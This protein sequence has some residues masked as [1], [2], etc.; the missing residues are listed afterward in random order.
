MGDL[1]A[2]RDW[3]EVRVKI[4]TDGRL[5]ARNVGRLLQSLNTAGRSV[6]ATASLAPRVEIVSIASG[7]IEIVIAV[8]ALGV[9]ATSLAFQIREFFKTNTGAVRVGRD[10]IVNDNATSISIS[11][12]TNIFLIGHQDVPE[13]E[14]MLTDM[15]VAARAP[16]RPSV[17]TVIRGPHFGRLHRFSGDWWVELDSRPGMTLRIRDI[18]PDHEALTGDRRY[19]LIG[20][21]HIAPEGEESTFVLRSA[22]LL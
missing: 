4:E 3:P 17:P 6:P 12:G 16:E 13:M 11:G 19:R 22:Q 21:A 1:R 10:L 2:I 7:S 5:S 14:D 9:S 18:R 20:D 8:L 15:R